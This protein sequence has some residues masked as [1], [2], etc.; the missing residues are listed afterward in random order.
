[1]AE[2]QG[3]RLPTEEVLSNCILLIVA[4]HETTTRLIANGLHLLPQHPAQMTLLRRRPELMPNAIEE[5]LRFEGPIQAMLRFV[6]EDMTFHGK[7]LKRNQLV[8]AVIAGAN[9][10]PRAFEKPETFDITREDNPHEGFG[11]GIHLCLGLTLAR[12]EARIALTRLLKFFPEMEL[13][14]SI[15]WTGPSITR[16]MDQ[17]YVRVQATTAGPIID[18]YVYVLP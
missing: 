9:R 2:E 5:M 10:D 8:L 15:V 12:L 18:L 14:R 7:K 13:A 16:G 4:G 1:M 3:D 17:L 11:Y 6:S